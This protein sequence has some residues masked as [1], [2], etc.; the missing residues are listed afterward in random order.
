MSAAEFGKIFHSVCDDFGLSQEARAQAWR[1]CY[2][3]NWKLR[4]YALRLY[5]MLAG[6]KPPYLAS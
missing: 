5:L 2:T 3:A 4:P 1:S 6:T